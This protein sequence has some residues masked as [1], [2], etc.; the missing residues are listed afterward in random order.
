MLEQGELPAGVVWIKGQLELGDVGQYL[1]WQFV[2]ALKQKASLAA[3]KGILGGGC[4][5][6][7]AELSRSESANEYVCKEETRSRGPWE[8][9]AK[10]I[11][12]NSKIDW[13]SVWSAAVAGDLAKIPPSIRVVSYRSIRAIG[14]DFAKPTAIIREVF[15]FWGASQTGKSRRAWNEAG[16]GAYSKCPRSKF[17]DGYQDE[18]AVVVDEFRGN[19]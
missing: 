17:W 13:D 9:G 19:V 15:V 5:G 3:L 7:H 4:R 2:I 1:H 12:R 16:L 14:S 8:F 18:E 11:R 6:V 10:P